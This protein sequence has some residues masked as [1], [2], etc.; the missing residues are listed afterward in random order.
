MSYS[1]SLRSIKMWKKFV[2]TAINVFSL[3]SCMIELLLAQSTNGV[4]IFKYV[5]LIIK[6]IQ[7]KLNQDF[8][9]LFEVIKE[10][11]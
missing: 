4:Q 5:N 7:V 8:K 9:S 2:Y 3:F 10:F 6:C 11:G 1:V